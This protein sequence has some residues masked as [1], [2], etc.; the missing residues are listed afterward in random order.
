MR[1]VVTAILKKGDKILI[2][3]RGKRVNTFIGK[4]SGISGR[5]ESTP[6]ES[7][8]REIEE[9]T[10]IPA[11]HAT[12]IREG[13]PIMA[14][15]ENFVFKIYPFL[16]EVKEDNIRLNWENINY[17]WILPKDITRYKTVPKLKEVIEEVLQ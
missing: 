15:G 10:G 14:E 9:E 3:E 2:V 8:L 16:F 12:L 7:V 6:L 13:S 4:W 5:M 1:E 17:R 11:E